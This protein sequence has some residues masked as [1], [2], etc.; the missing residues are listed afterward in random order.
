MKLKYIYI[1]FFVFFTTLN[2]AQDNVELKTTISKKKLGIHQRMRIQFTVNKQGADHF[3]LPEFKNFDVVGGPSSSINQSWINGTVS[4]AQTYTYIIK[5][6]K[7]GEFTIPSASI[8]Y[9]R[10]RV[11]SNTVQVV[12]VSENEIPKDVNDP[13]YIASQNVHLVAET[14]KNSPYVGEGIYVVYKLYFSHNIGFSDWR[15]NGTPQYNGFWN[16]DIE[17]GQ[18]EVKNGTYKDDEYRFIVLKRA[19]LIPQKSGE[20]FI[21]PIQMD[22]SVNVPTGRGDFFGNAI[23]RRV[24]YSTSSIKRIVK[25]KELPY[26]DKPADFTGAVGDFDF[27]ISASKDILRAN[28]TTQV[29]VQ[30]SGKGNLKLF[31]IPKIETPE[32]LEVYTPEHD[33]KV[34]TT[35]YGLSGKIGDTYTIVPEYK[36]KYKIPEV[37][38]SYFSLKEKAYKTIVTDPLIID[39]TEGKVL[40]GSSS[41]IAKDSNAIIKQE[42]VAT[43]TNFRY[44]QNRTNFESVEQDI[45]FKSNTFYLLLFLPFLAIPL[46]IVIGKKKAK[47]DGDIAGSRLRKA[48]KLARKYLSQAK[49]QL[50]KNEAFYISLEKALHNYLKATLKIETSDISKERITEILLN[51]KVDE[52]IVKEFIDV[53]NDC[54]FARYTPTTNTMMKEEFN[55]AKLVI[56]KIDKQI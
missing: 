31:E 40:P 13:A 25:V 49:K 42:I 51:K 55:K 16:Q 35:L 54:D 24:N 1:L 32:E 21:E 5:P 46:G 4:Y 27:M 22:I 43:D 41:S 38:F 29:N 10:K 11:K 15:I 9:R 3:E 45:F 56:A 53:L 12:V 48:D 17:V 50:G 8:E 7:I 30:V 14:S 44:I 18:P 28:E 37:S 52:Q 26:K 2:F 47:R 33:E 19:L 6:K 34:N 20:L 23:T 36:G 39:V